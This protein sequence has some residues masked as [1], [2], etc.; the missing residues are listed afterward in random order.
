MKFLFAVN[1]NQA[2]GSNISGSKT[3]V[4]H[5]DRPTCSIEW[6][7][8][9]DLSIFHRPHTHTTI[10]NTTQSPFH[11]IMAFHHMF[12]GCEL[13]FHVIPSKGGETLCIFVAFLIILWF[14][15]INVLSYTSLRFLSK[16]FFVYF[17]LK[18]FFFIPTSMN[19]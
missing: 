3:Y 5:M 15:R 14:D 1:S 16:Q 7:A 11:S 13:I 18:Q 4:Y 9:N 19:M 10:I 8:N 17:F 6:T 2:S 12:R